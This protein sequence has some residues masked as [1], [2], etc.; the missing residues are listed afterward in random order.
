MNNLIKRAAEARRKA[1]A[2]Y[3][4]FKV[5]AALESQDG[6]IFTGCNVENA[7]YGATCCAERTAIAKAVSEGARK[8]RRIAIVADTPEP[9][10]PCGICRE[11]LEEFSPHI[12]VIMANTRG[13]ILVAQLDNLLPNAFRRR[14]L[15]KKS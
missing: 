5:G 1:Y 13:K 7:S 14:N 2:P 12:D 10:P 11:V 3:S 6:R 8:F 15:K 4:G 9:C